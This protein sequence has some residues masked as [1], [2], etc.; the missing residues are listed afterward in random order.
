MGLTQ[1]LGTIPLAIFTDASNNVGIGGSPSGS[2]KFDVSGTGRFTSTLLVGG[3]ISLTSGI[4]S[5][6][7]NAASGWPSGGVGLRYVNNRL[8]IYGGPTDITFQKNSNTGPNLIILESGAATFSSTI[9]MGNTLTVGNQ[10]GADTTVITGGSGFGSKVSFNS[11][12]GVAAQIT[13]NT[14]SFV[15]RFTGNFGIGTISPGNKLQV[16]GNASK[17]TA[18]S[19]LANS[20]FN[21]KTDI[22]T[23]E[24]ALDRINKIRVVSFKY[25]DTYIQSHNSIKDY[26]YHN[27]IAQEYQEIYPDYVYDSKEVFEGHNV[28]QVDTNPMYIDSISAI[29]ELSKIV[30]LQE[31]QI[32]ELSAK[33]S[34]LENKS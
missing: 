28:L 18:G 12:S 34:A 1:K 22:N 10:G 15:N 20:D 7:G 2:Y 33:V 25:K 3:D 30:K 16:E 19:W 29:Q 31:I 6:S 5:I 21:I 26:Y 9:S 23:I 32:Q 27:V 8:L 24:G 13:G 17:T 4:L 14:D 11:G